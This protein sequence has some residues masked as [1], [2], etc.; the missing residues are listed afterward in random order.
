MSNQTEPTPATTSVSADASID[1][2]IVQ[3]CRM[4][5][6]RA[7]DLFEELGL[8]RGQPRLLHVLW[9]HEGRTH[10]ELAER[11]HVQPATITKMLQRMQEA[12]FVQR[13]RDSED[14]RVSRV[15]LT[16]AGREIQERVRQVWWQLEEEALADFAPEERALLYRFLV[17]IRD[18]FA[19]VHACKHADK[20]ADKHQ[21]SSQSV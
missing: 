20:H 3:V 4:H 13:R 5:H 6:R 8:Y 17:Q 12:G 11:L 7:H 19:R 18:N 21:T 2:L 9:E 10:S 16:A 1:L 15:Y 14:Q